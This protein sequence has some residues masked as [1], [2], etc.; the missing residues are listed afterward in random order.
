MNAL[1]AVVSRRLFLQASLSASGALVLAPRLASG[2]DAP[3][4]VP[5]NPLGVLIRIQPDNRVVIGA[6]GAEIGQGVKTSLPMI[7]AEE[8]DADWSQ[9]TV[10][11]M[12]MAIDFSGAEPRWRWGAQGAGGSTSIPDGWAELRQFGAQGRWLMRQA[13]ATQW[14]IPVE[15]VKTEAGHALHPDGRRLPRS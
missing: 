8:L 10:E 9:V 5:E 13:A 7:L 4:R 3:A 12:P 1:A 6:T 14:G 2:Q 15:D 11:Q